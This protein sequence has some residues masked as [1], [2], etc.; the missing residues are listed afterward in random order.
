MS[1]LKEPRS[2]MP[3][4]KLATLIAVGALLVAAPAAEADHPKPNLGLEITAVDAATRTVT[5]IQHCTT[6]DREGRSASFTVAQDI[7]VSQF[8]PGMMWGVAVDA[9]GVILGSGDMPCDVPS[10]PDPDAHRGTPSFAPGFLNRV[11]SFGVQ[12]HSGGA[13]KLLVTIGKV[14][15]LPKSMSSQDDALV[16]RA[17][18]VVLQGNIRIYR[19]GKPL[20]PG[21]SLDDLV[22][23]AVIHG[24]L[25]APSKWDK[26]ERGE[27]LPTISAAKIYLS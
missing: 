23:K 2:L 19:H 22:G 9:N 3:R 15:N 18:L 7:D 20:A 25:L 12:V 1:V 4:K 6:A 16:H 8:H 5:G 21:G 17:A 14:L 13:G 10:Q 24:K 27:T 11:W 26:D